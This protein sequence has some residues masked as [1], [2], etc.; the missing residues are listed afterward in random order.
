MGRFLRSFFSLSQCRKLPVVLALLWTAG[1]LF[2]VLCA[3]LGSGVPFLIARTVVRS[4]EVSFIWL[5]LIRL[6]PLAIS[7]HSV[8]ECRSVV[9]IPAVFIRAVVF[10]YTGTCVLTALGSSAWLIYWL[11]FFAD[12]LIVTIHWFVWI[13][14]FREK[15]CFSRW[16]PICAAA[17][18][19]LITI[20]DYLFVV[21]F[22]MKLI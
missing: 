19:V 4:H 6:F 16:N 3:S 10:S 13:C 11:L 15:E 17:A 1:L 12:I 14:A 20:F 22:L 21:P 9:L 7:L 8:F 2:G 5:I 18:I